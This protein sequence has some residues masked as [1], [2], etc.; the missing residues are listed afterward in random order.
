MG[1]VWAEIQS[2]AADYLSE[3]DER[4]LMNTGKYLVEADEPVDDEPVDEPADEPVDDVPAEEPA[5][6]PVDDTEASIDEPVDDEPIDDEPMDDSA[7]E[8]L[9]DVA[10]EDITTK[11]VSKA[12]KT[13]SSHLAK[14]EKKI[15]GINF[16]KLSFA[17]QNEVLSAL[18]NVYSKAQ[19]LASEMDSFNGLSW[20]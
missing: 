11:D 17:K 15:N 2:K 1:K 9:D 19:E 20:K 18:Q 16:N 3:M 10:P 12:V 5:E 14:T 4:D 8:S 7:S 13:L 6:E